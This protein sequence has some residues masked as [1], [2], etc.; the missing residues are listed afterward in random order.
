MGKLKQTLVDWNY[1][2]GNI[3]IQCNYNHKVFRYP[4]FKVPEKYFDKRTKSL[5]PCDGLFDIEFET[6]RIQDLFTKVNTAIIHILPTLSKEEG[7]KQEMVN[8]YIKNHI[9]IKIVVPHT[10]SLIED[11]ENWIEEYKKQ[12]QQEDKL[13]GNDRKLHPS[14]KD[15]ISC[16]NLLKDFEHDNCEDKPLSIEDINN[17]FLCNFMEYAY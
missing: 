8:E 7:I 11:F 2:R 6:K 9:D 10:K 14:A 17:D 12:K 3:V 1:F 4:A 15:Y 13:K 5:K 16:K